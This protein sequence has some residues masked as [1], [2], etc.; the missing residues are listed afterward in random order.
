MYCIAAVHR[1][2][3]SILFFG[4][5]TE[6]IELDLAMAA[7]LSD[8]DCISTVDDL[9]HHIHDQVTIAT[10]E[11]MKRTNFMRLGL[12]DEDNAKIGTLVS[13]KKAAFTAQVADPSELRK[14]SQF[15]KFRRRLT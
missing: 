14:S 10:E 7:R 5:V 6:G 13:K 12:V 15:S 11:T 3:F 2:K 4:T 8:V 1:R 9:W